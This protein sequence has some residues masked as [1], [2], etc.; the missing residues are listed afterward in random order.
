MLSIGFISFTA[1]WVL[2]ALTALPMIW[3]F[4]RLRPPVPTRVVFPPLV[5]LRRLI[6]RQESSAL[7]PPWLV[8][9]RFFLT[10][11]FPVKEKN[12]NL[13]KNLYSKK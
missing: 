13:V 5:L 4:L 10:V 9:L 2:I 12:V 11:I 3:W 6:G 8:A 7:P 1:P